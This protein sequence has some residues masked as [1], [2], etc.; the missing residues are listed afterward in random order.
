MPIKQYN[1]KNHIKIQHYKRTKIK[2][3]RIFV[4]RKENN[5]K[6]YEMDDRMVG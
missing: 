4:K 6:Q 3:N 5:R 1:K 2:N